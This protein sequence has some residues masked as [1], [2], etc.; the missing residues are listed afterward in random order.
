M[1][2]ISATILLFLVM[3]PFGN[4]PV[5]LCVLKNV[6]AQKK[7]RSIARELLIA[8]AVLILFLLIG[9]HILTVLHI[10]EPSLRITGGIIL[11]MIAIKMIFGAPEEMY[12]KNPAGEPF[13]VPLAIPCLAGPSAIAT[14]MLLTGQQPNRW[15]E[16]LLALI[17]A[18]FATSIILLLS[19]KLDHILGERGMSALQNL[20]GL[21]LTALAVEMFLEGIR[22]AFHFT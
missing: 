10:S 1:T 19:T 14:V 4:A 5:F 16:W 12:A 18:W 9:P 11:F 13:I 17:L 7:T 20:M 8:L 6:P 15:L 3:D 21:I 2:V 22:T